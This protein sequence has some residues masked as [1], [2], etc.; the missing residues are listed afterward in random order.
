MITPRK[1]GNTISVI[2][3]VYRAAAGLEKTLL[4]IEKQQSCN[5]AVKIIVAND[6]ADAMVSNVCRHHGVMMVAIAPHRGSYFARNRALE[7]ASDEL[8]VFLDAGIEMA[9]NWLF[10]ALSLLGTADYLAGEVDISAV[11]RP[12]AAEAYEKT[13]AYPI[14]EYMRTFHFGGAGNLLVKKRLLETVGSFD[15]RLFSGGDLEFGDRVY[16]AGFTQVYLATP[17]LLHPPRRALSLFRKQFRVRIGHGRL[18]RLFPGRFF[19]SQSLSSS[20]SSVLRALLP[21]HPAYVK[22]EFSPNENVPVWR[23]FF[24][25]WFLKICRAL[26]DLVAILVPTPLPPRKPTQI[27]W[28]DFSIHGR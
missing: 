7:R 18:V 10:E 25:L 6:G 28:F 8:V 27:E 3:P 5:H 21:P 26:A 24:F 13:H 9:K 4:S 1:N 11:P 17:V 23:R 12:T 15:Q 22:S 20:I 16:Q 19:P 2:I 14:A